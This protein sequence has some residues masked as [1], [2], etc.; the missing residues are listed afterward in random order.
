MPQRRGRPPMS[1]F[2]RGYTPEMREAVDRMPIPSE[3]KCCVCKR[4]RPKSQ[5]SNNQLSYLRQAMF[6]LGYNNIRDQQ[7]AKCSPC[8]NAQVCEELCH[9]CGHYRAIDQFARNQRNRENPIC[10]PCM[11]YQMSL[12]P[13][14]KPLAIKDKTVVE[15]KGEGEDEDEELNSESAG[16]S[17]SVAL[18]GSVGHPESPDLLSSTSQPEFL[19][20]SVETA[21]ILQDDSTDSDG[22]GN[23]SGFVKVK[24]HKPHREPVPDPEPAPGWAPGT[25]KV[26][27]GA[28]WKGGRFL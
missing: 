1:P 18:S 13:A 14:D 21:L 15:D 22:S 2:A 16:R 5:Y 28:P 4:R 7:V 23:R 27:D 8:T 10:Q 24:A 12:D 19:E 20:Q 3:I 26:D 11:N 9:R 25:R 6:Q 17:G